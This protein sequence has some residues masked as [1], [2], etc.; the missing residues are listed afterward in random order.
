MLQSVPAQLCHGMR[1][2]GISCLL[3]STDIIILSKY[4]IK[5]WQ[6][7]FARVEYWVYLVLTTFHLAFQLLLNL[8][9]LIAKLVGRAVY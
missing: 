9:E 1:W 5:M 8:E 4:H 6:L 2:M 3:G 7:K